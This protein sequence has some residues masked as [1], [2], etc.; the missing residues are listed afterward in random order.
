MR[1]GCQNTSH[2]QL[3]SVL[4]QPRGRVGKLRLDRGFVAAVFS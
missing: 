2:N 4:G 1:P 3:I